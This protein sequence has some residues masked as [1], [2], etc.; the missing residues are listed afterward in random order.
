MHHDYHITLCSW[1]CNFR[2]IPFFRLSVGRSVGQ[3]VGL[4]VIICTSVFLLVHFIMLYVYV[5][6]KCSKYTQSWGSS[7]DIVKYDP[8]TNLE[9]A[10]GVT[11]S[12]TYALTSKKFIHNLK[13]LFWSRKHVLIKRYLLNNLNDIWHINIDAWCFAEP[14]FWKIIFHFYL[15]TYLATL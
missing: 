9:H 11:D 1:K 15:T 4:S 6:Y 13:M 14:D 12:V 2:M 10:A 5:I 7:D 3:S 8:T